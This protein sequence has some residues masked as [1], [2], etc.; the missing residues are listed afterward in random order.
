M[1]LWL[2]TM[3]EGGGRSIVR[4]SGTLDQG[5]VLSPAN[6]DCFIK[7]QIEIFLNA[8]YDLLIYQLNSICVFM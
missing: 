5:N 6:I 8:R 2:L 3:Y 7:A 1:L 4:G